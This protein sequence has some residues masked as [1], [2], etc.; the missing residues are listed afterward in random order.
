MSSVHDEIPIKL[1]KFVGKPLLL[2]LV[3][4]I[5]S[6]FITG[7]FPKQIKTAKVVPLYKKGEVTK[8][9]IIVLFQYYLYQKFLKRQCIFG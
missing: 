4:L 9:P 8:Y 1:F 3:H 6:S 7:I 5:N 2:P